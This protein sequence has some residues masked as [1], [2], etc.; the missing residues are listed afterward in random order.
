M[1]NNEVTFI[2]A[3]TVNLAMFYMIK[4]PF[5]KLITLGVAD[6]YDSKWAAGLI[7]I[8]VYVVS[9]MLALILFLLGLDELIKFGFIWVLPF[10]LGV[11]S[12]LSLASFKAFAHDNMVV[13][14]LIIC[15]CQ[16][17]VRA[18]VLMYVRLSKF[19]WMA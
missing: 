13:Y 2:L 4:R 15:F 1:S 19:F 16:N 9:L 10:K 8:Y 3:M 5:T 6:M 12:W 7:S 11:I 18:V 14:A 17:L